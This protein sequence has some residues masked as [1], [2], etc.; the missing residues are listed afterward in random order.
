ML[1]VVE[2]DHTT[3]TTRGD[4]VARVKTRGADVRTIGTSD[5]IGRILEEYDVRKGFTDRFPIWDVSYE[6][7]EKKTLRLRGDNLL[8]LVYTGYV[9]IEFNVT[10]YGFHTQLNDGRDGRRKSTRGC[11]NLRTLG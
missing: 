8:E 11:H 6:V 9:R 7:G 4:D 2:H 5:R 3:D 1:F 10:K